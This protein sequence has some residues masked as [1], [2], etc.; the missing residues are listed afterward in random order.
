MNDEKTILKLNDD[1]LQEAIGWEPFDAQRE[2]IEAYDDGAK[3]IRLVCGVRWGKTMLAAYLALREWLKTDKHIWIVAPNYQL[4]EKVFNY[5]KLWIEEAFPRSSKLISKNPRPRIKNPK[6]RSWIECKSAD[7]E[8][9]LT[10]EELD[11]VIGDE[12]AWW[13]KEIHQRYLRARV[14]SRE[15]TTIYISTPRGKNWFYDDYLRC[16]EKSNAYA[17]QKPSKSSPYFKDKWW[18]NIKEELPT[19]TFNQEYRATFIEGAATVFK[20]RDIRA[21]INSNCLSD[22]KPD[23]RYTMG[24]DLA[25]HKDFTVVTVIDKYSHEIVYWE[26]WQKESWT[27][28]RKRLV[29]ISRKYNRCRVVLD[30]TGLG[31]PVADELSHQGVISDDINF[32]SKKSEIIEKLRL[33]IEDHSLVLPSEDTLLNE[34]RAFGKT[35]KSKTTGKMLRKPRYSAPEGM[36]DDSVDSLALAVWGLSSSR[37]ENPKKLVKQNNKKSNLSKNYK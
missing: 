5:V 10:G 9:S 8:K 23:R 20:D 3:D 27:F 6:K 33:Y 32:S 19:D 12:V 31:D 29:E 11:L 28:T 7:S 30:S 36:H 17:V 26:R 24:V 15:G 35:M 25:K 14:S 18:E 4:S 21:V 16:K 37:K 22:P 1:K 2:I 34:L 13:S